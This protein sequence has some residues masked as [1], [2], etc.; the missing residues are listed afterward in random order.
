MELVKEE[1]LKHD[2]V[3]LRAIRR[4]MATVIPVNLLHLWTWRNLRD[5][6][7]GRAEVDIDQL[8]RHTVYKG[9]DESAQGVKDMWE[10]LEGFTQEQRQAFLRFVWGRTTLPQGEDDWAQ[11][12]KVESWGRTDV[13]LPIS[14]T[15][16]F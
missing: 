5:R 9:W 12:F 1:R 15:C 11:P 14:H 2:E 3:Q 16:Y 4:G 10:V 7:C 6:V 8:R 13:K